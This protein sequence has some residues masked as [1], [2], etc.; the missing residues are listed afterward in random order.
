M[1]LKRIKMENFKT[2]RKKVEI[3]IFK[4]FTGITG[5]NG[6]GK[7]NIADAIL[8]VLGPRSSKMVRAKRLQDLIF[9]GND[10]WKAAKQCR[11]TLVF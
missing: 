8:F 11:V 7:S 3:P 9:H 10:R 2:F 4:G 6:S 1:Y 5:P